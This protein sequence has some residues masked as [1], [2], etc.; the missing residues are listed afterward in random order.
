MGVHFS[1]PKR[2]AIF[3]VLLLLLSISQTAAHGYTGNSNSVSCDRVSEGEP[4]LTVDWSKASFRSENAVEHKRESPRVEDIYRPSCNKSSHSLQRVVGYYETWTIRRRCNVFWPERIPPGVYT[5]INVAYAVI[6]PDTFEVRPSLLADI[7]LFTRLTDLKRSDP[8]LKVYIALGG[9]TYS[10]PGPTEHTFSDLVASEANQTAFIK[11]LTKFITAFDFDG[12]DLDW[13]YPGAE[14]RGGRPQDFANFPRFLKNLKAAL[15][16][17]GGRAGL[18]ITLPNSYQYL[19]HY[20]I[21]R[22]RN[23]VD[24]FNVMTYD[25]HGTYRKGEAWNDESL[26]AHTNLTEIQDS[27]DLLWQYDISPQQVVLGMAFY[28]R[29]FQVTDPS[30][31]MPGCPF[32][33]GGEAQRCSYEVGVLMNSEIDDVVARNNLTPILDSNAAVKMATW[34]NQWLAYDDVDTFQR[35][36][37]FARSQ[38]LGGLMVWAV[39]HDHASGA[40]SQALKTAARREFVTLADDVTVDDSILST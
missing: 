6:D 15:S 25:L 40:Y 2:C 32:A 27:L 11:S 33:S 35:K 10:S 29:T 23:H 37:E 9:S 19:Q 3:S 39:S 26:N 12:V 13:Q 22:I 1:R 24:F 14:N 36:A 17:T 38:C 20:D 34:D 28:G 8:D 30:C 21:Q 18:S 31:N 4:A 16:Q 7:N 5:H